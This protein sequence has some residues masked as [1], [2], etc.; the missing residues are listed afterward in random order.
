MIKKI[1]DR[2]GPNFIKGTE[3]VIKDL[4]E[5]MM[6]IAS[7]CTNRRKDD[8]KLYPYVKNA[9]ISEYNQRGAEGLLSKTEGGQSSSFDNI[10]K[11]M[12]E[13][14]ISAHLRRLP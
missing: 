6:L 1:K 10:V 12:K 11:K 13:D 2:L 8:S 9:V 3:G 4:L 5:D 14:L 7:H